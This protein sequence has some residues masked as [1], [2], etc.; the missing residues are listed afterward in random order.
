MSL[1][2]CWMLLAV[3]A[4]PRYIA[5]PGAPS[6]GVLMDYLAYDHVQNRVWVPAGNTGSVYVI[7]VATEHVTRL[8]GFVTAEVERQGVKRT[9]GPSAASVGEGVVYVGNRGDS[10]VCAIDAAS[11]KRAS[12]VKLA[13]VPDGVAYVASAREVWVTTPRVN[14]LAILDA[15]DASHLSLKA[16]VSLEGAPEGY[17]VDD[18]RGV[19]YT[20][21]EDK[22]QTL[23][24]DVKSRKVTRTWQPG[25][26]EDGPRGLS[27]DRHL[28]F[29]VVAC[30]NHLTVLDAGHDGKRLSSLDTGGGVDNID[31]LE[32]RHEL[33]AAA[34]ATAKLTVARL[35]AAGGLTLLSSAETVAGAR[36]AVV[37]DEGKAYVTDSHGGRILVVD[38]LPSQP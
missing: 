7:D 12:C 36:N 29:L 15:T 25:C 8:E 11:L 4:A 14:A 10:S 13:A 31:Y 28:N 6:G 23:S 38:P 17:A 26:G 20:N 3:V 2:A 33:Y 24:I 32:A 34:G 1:R 21:L 35:D 19:F 37:S 18:G 27:L 16:S 5:L 9:V 30:P 22:D